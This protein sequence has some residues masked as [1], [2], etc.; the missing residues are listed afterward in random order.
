MI[1]ENTSKDTII[2]PRKKIICPCCKKLLVFK[3]TLF[4]T[5]TAIICW[6]C[7]ERIAPEKMKDA[8]QKEIDD[9]WYMWSTTMTTTGLEGDRPITDVKNK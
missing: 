1:F 6:H 7:H 2:V 3:R 5:I 4:E 9:D 8:T